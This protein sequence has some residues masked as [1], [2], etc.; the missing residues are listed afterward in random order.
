M[1]RQTS[2]RVGTDAAVGGA[3]ADGWALDDGWALASVL[4]AALASA[5]A[6]TA[7]LETVEA[8]ALGVASSRTSVG[9]KH[10]FG[11]AGVSAQPCQLSPATAEAMNTARRRR[12]AARLSSSS[13][14]GPSS[15]ELDIASS[16]QLDPSG[17]TE[18]MS[19]TGPCRCVTY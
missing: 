14:S 9:L 5:L 4:V 3:L 12:M 19:L 2:G 18:T 13:S 6:G 10:T 15:R 17:T 16:K 1:R 7:A 8:V 11:G